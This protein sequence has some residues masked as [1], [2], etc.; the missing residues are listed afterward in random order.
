MRQPLKTPPELVS[1]QLGEPNSE[2]PTPA[3]PPTKSVIYAALGLPPR[4]DPLDSPDTLQALAA[5]TSTPTIP[6]AF[7]ISGDP[8][9]AGVVAQTPER[10]MPF[11]VM[12]A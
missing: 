1:L 11:R 2:T 6:I 10:D 7:V 8:L 3:S 9:K 12:M 4:G 5:K